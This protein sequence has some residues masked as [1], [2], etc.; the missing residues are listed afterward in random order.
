MTVY[1][2][3][4]YARMGSAVTA[5]PQQGPS[6]VTPGSLVCLDLEAEGKLLWKVAPEE[7]WA[8]EGAPVVRGGD[9]F[10]AMRRNDIRPQA[11]VACFDAPTGRLRW[12]R[13]VSAAETPARG[14]LPQS[15]CNLLSLSGDTIYYNTNLAPW[16]P[17]RPTTAGSFGSASIPATAAATWPGPAPDW[18]RDLN[19]CLVHDD[20][21]LVAPADSPRILALDAR[22]GQI[23][24]QSGTDVED[25]VDL[26]GVA[27]GELIAGRAEL[28]RIDLAVPTAGRSPR[29]A[30][31]PENPAMAVECCLV[32]W[33]SPTRKKI[34]RST[35][36]AEPTRAIHHCSETKKT[37]R[38]EGKG[39]TNLSTKVCNLGTRSD[40]ESNRRG[41]PPRVENSQR[42]FLHRIALVFK[43]H[44]HHGDGQQHLRV[45]V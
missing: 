39:A 24:W 44:H 16:R 26:V 7:G 45:A 27:G 9:L 13:F 8:F 10:V 40:A 28:Y 42:V 1:E 22:T 4:L 38:R 23:L 31:R 17:C 5:Q 35:K 36:T 30:G 34:I 6:P 41:S 33:S 3:R 29:L 20:T 21:L 14:M 43:Q 2:N 11:H 12:R 15:T 32:R 37:A 18:Q 19:P 25:V